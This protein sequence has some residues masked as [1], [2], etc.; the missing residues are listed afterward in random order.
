M[1]M[2]RTE[3]ELE[4]EGKVILKVPYLKVSELYRGRTLGVSY[5]CML[6]LPSFRA[7]P[8]SRV[9]AFLPILNSL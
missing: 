8:L 9:R 7:L 2:N 4:T 6:P 1:I 5:L 3:L